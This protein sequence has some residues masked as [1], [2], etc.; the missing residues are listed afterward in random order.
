MHD[1]D[2]DKPTVVLDYNAIKEELAASEELEDD[3][4]EFNIDNLIGD[5]QTEYESSELAYDFN[6]YLFDYKDSFFSNHY[7]IIEMEQGLGILNGLQEL[8]KTLSEDPRSL[9]VF[10][11]NQAPKVVNQLSA[12]IKK[13]FPN[14]RTMIIAN[15]LSPQKAKAHA[16]SKFAANCYLSHPFDF[17]GFHSE[18]KK[19]NWE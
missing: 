16:E 9:I 1:D 7:Q 18:V 3:N 2:E 8:N 15:K 4:I 14:T 11:Y 13:K 10:Y 17:E 19:L 5:N 12:Q 6:I